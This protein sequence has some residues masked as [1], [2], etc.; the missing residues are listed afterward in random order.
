MDTK[1]SSKFHRMHYNFVAARL[2]ETIEVAGDAAG[3]NILYVFALN[4]ARYFAEDNENFD[5]LRFLDACSPDTKKYPI[6]L[7]WKGE[8]GN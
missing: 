4:C 5:P 2:R 7:L 3:R 1:K 8:D 6:R